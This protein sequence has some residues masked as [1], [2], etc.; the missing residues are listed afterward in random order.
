MTNSYTNAVL[1]VIAACLLVLTC[2]PVFEVKPASAQ[3]ALVSTTEAEE[4][5]AQPVTAPKRAP[6]RD[7]VVNVNIVGI[8]GW[9]LLERSA[10]PVEIESGPVP[11]QIEGSQGVCGC[12]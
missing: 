4:S 8:G 12:P 9:K 10:L 6:N 7:E 11:V 3:V 1:T 5:P 2:R